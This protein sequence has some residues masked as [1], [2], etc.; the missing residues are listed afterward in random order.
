MINM[1]FT[2]ESIKIFIERQSFKLTGSRFMAE[3]YPDYIRP[4]ENSDW[5]YYGEYSEEN[6]NFLKLFGFEKVNWD[7]KRP[8]I[9]NAIDYLLNYTN[10]KI[11]ILTLI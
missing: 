2:F 5:D 10:T 7:E 3:K 8:N 4:T 1:D 11:P 6:L 9:K